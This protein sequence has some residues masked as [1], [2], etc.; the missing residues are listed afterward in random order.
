MA[1]VKVNNALVKQGERDAAV[2]EFLKSMKLGKGHASGYTKTD[3][4]GRYAGYRDGQ[5]IRVTSA[6]AGIGRGAAGQL[7]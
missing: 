1:L 6:K 5:S 3:T 7:T 2:A 4:G